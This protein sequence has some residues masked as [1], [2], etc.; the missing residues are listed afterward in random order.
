MG[1]K[2]NAEKLISE[3]ASKD[4]SQGA[5]QAQNAALRKNLADAKAI[6]DQE[7]VYSKF[8]TNIAALMPSGVVLD[9]LSL[10]PSTFGSPTSLQFFAVSTEAALSLKEKFETSPFFSGVNFQSLTSNTNEQSSA[11]PISATL[12]LVINKGIAQ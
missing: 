3:N 9:N 2:A 6:L 5:I 7:V 11:Y 10:S 4:T 1:T 12:G 8:V